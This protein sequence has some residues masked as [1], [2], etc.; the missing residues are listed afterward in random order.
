MSGHCDDRFIGCDALTKSRAQRCNA[1]SGGLNSASGQHAAR[2]LLLHGSGTQTP[3]P[4]RC[5]PGTQTEP[6]P[7]P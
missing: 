5:K 7:Q 4:I 3:N 6:I 2:Q 1:P